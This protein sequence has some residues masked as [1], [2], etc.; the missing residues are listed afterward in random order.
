MGSCRH[1]ILRNLQFSFSL[2][3]AFNKKG[4]RN[5]ERWD[6]KGSSLRCL[7][8]PILA[9]IQIISTSSFPTLLFSTSQPS[10]QDK[11]LLAQ[12]IRRHPCCR[13]NTAHCFEYLIRMCTANYTTSSV[14]RQTVSQSIDIEFS[15]T[16]K[17][18]RFIIFSD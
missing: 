2:C 10:R 4:L 6:K 13:S 1:R 16:M 12:H 18:N 8:K 15:Q 3:K 11:N 5:V 14:N 17:G 9:K 7:N